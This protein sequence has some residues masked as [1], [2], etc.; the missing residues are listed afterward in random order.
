M[1]KRS[2]IVYRTRFDYNLRL[3]FETYFNVTII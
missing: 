1:F 3:S 2:I